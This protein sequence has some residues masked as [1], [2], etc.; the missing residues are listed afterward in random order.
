MCDD[1]RNQHYTKVV[2]G[3]TSEYSI[4]HRKGQ[5]LI[6][7]LETGCESKL[8]ILRAASTHYPVLRKFLHVHLQCVVQLWGVESWTMSLSSTRV[9]LALSCYGLPPPPE[10]RLDDH[11]RSV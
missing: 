8:R 1:C 11:Y 6:S 10:D 7:S 4:A 5:P 2:D 9:A 3:D